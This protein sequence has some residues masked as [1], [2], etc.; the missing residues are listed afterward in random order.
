MGKKEILSETETPRIHQNRKP[1]LAAVVA[2]AVALLFALWV[3][4]DEG[5]G[6][7]ADKLTAGM[8]IRFRTMQTRVMSDTER[9]TLVTYYNGADKIRAE[10]A[11][12]DADIQVMLTEGSRTRATIF[13]TPEDGKIYILRSRYRRNGTDSYSVE[14]PEMAV[15]LD[16]LMLDF[17]PDRL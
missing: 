16:Q 17:T 6:L 1:L 9:N 7:K 10:G 5:A 11:P 3:F 14:S 8:L 13:Y 12:A 2:V 15:F 4:Y